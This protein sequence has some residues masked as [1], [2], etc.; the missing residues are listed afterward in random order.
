MSS[1]ATEPNLAQ[2]ERE[3]TQGSRGKTARDGQGWVRVPHVTVSLLPGMAPATS[4][5]AAP[6]AVADSRAAMVQR[7]FGGFRRFPLSVLCLLAVGCGAPPVSPP[8]GAALEAPRG[9]A[10]SHRRPNMPDDC[11]ER[12]G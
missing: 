2:L 5:P 9:A 12:P 11:E 3:S 10:S 6:F 1:D 8:P 7:M 4:L